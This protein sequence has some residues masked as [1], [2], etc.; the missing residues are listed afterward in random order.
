MIEGHYPRMMKL[1]Q[2]FHLVNQI[3]LVIL[4]AVLKSFDSNLA[5][6]KPVFRQVNIPESPA[7]EP[8]ENPVLRIELVAC[9]DSHG[10]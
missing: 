9:V 8:T 2:R 3:G 7:S 1:I 10:I 6:K 4:G 5:A